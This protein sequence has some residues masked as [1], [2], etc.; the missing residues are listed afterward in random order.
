MV[1]FGHQAVLELSDEVLRAVKEGGST[2]SS[3]WAAAMAP[4]PGAQLLPQYAPKATDDSL[5]L[6]MGCAKY[7]FNDI[8]FG[9]LIGLP[10]LLDVGQCNDSYSAVRIAMGLA[11]ALGCEVND[12]PLTRLSKVGIKKVMCWVLR[13][14]LRLWPR[15]VP[16]ILFHYVTRLP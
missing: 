13:V 10:R 12:L 4:P 5:I 9:E 2:I 7:R 3:S 16:L 14:L 8:D 15:S 6:T 1:G 11:D